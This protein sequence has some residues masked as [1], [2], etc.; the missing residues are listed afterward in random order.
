MKL[1]LVRPCHA[2]RGYVHVLICVYS[3]VQACLHSQPQRGLWPVG[4][5]SQNQRCWLSCLEPGVKWVGVFFGRYCGSFRWGVHSYGLYS[6]DD[7]PAALII[8][9]ARSLAV[10]NTLKNQRCWL[11]CP[12]Y[13]GHDNVGHSYVGHNEI[14]HNYMGHNYAGDN[15]MQTIAM[16][17]TTMQAITI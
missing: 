16:L 15:Y 17:A 8:V 3:C 4:N 7:M 11:S 2:R 12:K 13:A 5:S 1:A 6:Y 14:G 9:W 10:G